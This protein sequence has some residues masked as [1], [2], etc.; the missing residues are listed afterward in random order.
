MDGVD[1]T[2][3]APWERNIGM[4]FQSYALWPHLDVWDNVAFGLV[5]RRLDKATIK[6]RVGAAVSLGLEPSQ[7]RWFPS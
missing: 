3:K 1:I 6:S 4:V 2:G 7:V 5:E